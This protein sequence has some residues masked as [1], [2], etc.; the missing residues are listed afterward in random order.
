ME[1]PRAARRRNIG[2]WA[3]AAAS[4]L[5]LLAVAFAVYIYVWR[6]DPVRST[7]TPVTAAPAEQ[8]TAP[9]SARPPAM[10]EEPPDVAAPPPPIDESDPFVRGLVSQL[11]SNPQVAGWLVSEDLIRRFTAAVANV[12]LGDSPA[13]HIEFM[14]PDE[15]FAVSAVESGVQVSPRSYARYDLFADAFASLDVDGT[16]TLFETLRPLIVSAYQD[17]GYDDEFDYTLTLAIERLLEVPVVEGPLQVNRRVITY[18]FS[19]PELEGLDAAQRHFLRMGP[20][21]VRMVQVKLRELV[22]ALGIALTR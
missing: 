12:A 22:P 17:L 19:D 13:P 1:K 15:R 3:A 21:N 14:A 7:G 8:P 2:R 9:V 6:P 20:R 18:E 4:A 11:S 16:V 5:L 10:L